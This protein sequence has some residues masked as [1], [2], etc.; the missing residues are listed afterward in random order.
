MN[1]QGSRRA[2]GG[3]A[4]WVAW[5]TL[6]LVALALLLAVDLAAYLVAA[7]RAQGAADAAALAAVAASDPRARASHLDGPPGGS[8]R[9]VAA[10]VARGM[11]AELVACD[12]APGAGEVEV[13]VTVDVRAIAVT[14]FAGREVE[15]TARAHLVP[16]SG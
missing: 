7:E 2:E 14:R 16:E 15:G 1:P 6:A 10:R 9:A 11:G 5:P 8:P 13:S 4:F 12:C 3:S